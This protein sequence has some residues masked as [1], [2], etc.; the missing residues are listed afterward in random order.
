MI[1]HDKYMIDGRQMV[2]DYRDEMLERIISWLEEI[3]IQE[4]DTAQQLREKIIWNLQDALAE[5]EKP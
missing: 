2:A 1:D 5:A 3:E 4:G